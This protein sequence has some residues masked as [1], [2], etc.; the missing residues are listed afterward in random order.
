MFTEPTTLVQVTGAALRHCGINS[1]L[2]QGIFAA[3]F[4]FCGGSFV[5]CGFACVHTPRILCMF[6]GAAGGN[7]FFNNSKLSSLYGIAFGVGSSLAAATFVSTT[8][9]KC[10]APVMAAGTVYLR[11][12]MNGVAF[13]SNGVG[14]GGRPYMLYGTIAIAASCCRQDF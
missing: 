1:M 9:M 4:L 8:V 12:S 13:T 6:I 7:L 2:C 11:A 3:L 5:R 14:D 10:L